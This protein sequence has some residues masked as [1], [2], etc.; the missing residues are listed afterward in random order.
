MT[1]ND[2]AAAY[3]LFQV[4]FAEVVDLL[5]GATFRLRER[6]EPGLKFEEVFDQPFKKLLRQFRDELKQFDKRSSVGADVHDLREACKI[7]SRIAVWRNDRIH[8]RVVMTESGYALYDWRTRHRLEMHQ[9][10]IVKNIELAIKV[11]VTLKSS[12][13]PLIGQLK[14]DE[15]LDK[16]FKSMPEFA[17]TED[18]DADSATA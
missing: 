11:S 13:S 17:E 16:L 6:R 8:A 3:G 2:T 14:L 12:V 9:D 15:E 18:D 4:V 10:V 7:M 5:A 1:F